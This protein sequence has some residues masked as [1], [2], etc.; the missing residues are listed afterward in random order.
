MHAT[1]QDQTCPQR[2]PELALIR[3]A[4]YQEQESKETWTLVQ[5]IHPSKHHV[6]RKL[7]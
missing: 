2:L 1:R 5:L 3:Q 4:R 7:V 6:R